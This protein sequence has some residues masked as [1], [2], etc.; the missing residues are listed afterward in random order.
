MR[1]IDEDTF[2]L[3]F[4]P[5]RKKSVWSPHNVNRI[6][7]LMKKGKMKQAGIDIIPEEIKKKLSIS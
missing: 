4:S 2:V 7:E 1:R 3:R 6:R 5:R